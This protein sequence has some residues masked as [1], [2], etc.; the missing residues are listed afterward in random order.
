MYAQSVLIVF[1]KAPLIRHVKTRLASTIGH[2]K[3]REVYLAMVKDLYKNINGVNAETCFYVDK[4]LGLGNLLP[5]K[6]SNN[7]FLQKG[8]DIG[9]KMYNAFKEVFFKGAD[10]AVLIGSDIPQIHSKLINE[11]LIKLDRYSLVLGPSLDGGYHLIGCRK[12][13]LNIKLFKNISWSSPA[14]LNQTEKIA[15]KQGLK[16]LEGKTLIDID[17]FSDL[18]KVVQ[19]TEYKSCLKNLI[20]L[21]KQNNWTE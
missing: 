16:Y 14:V 12:V 17:T 3:A 18:L 6:Y 21:V 1:L 11:Y 10:K 7:V 20:K 2:D 8:N 5:E 19:N 13:M 4:K 15:E 9:I